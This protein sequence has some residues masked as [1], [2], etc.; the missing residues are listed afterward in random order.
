[1]NDPKWVQ[2]KTEDGLNLP[3][4]LFHAPKSKEVVI[5]LHGMGSSVFYDDSGKLQTVAKKLVQKNISFFPFNNRGANLVRRFTVKKDGKEIKKRYGMAYEI[6]K[7]CCI[8]INA[9]LKY[10]KLLGF[11]EFILMGQSTGANKI[12]VYN[13]YQ[14]KNSIK[15]YILTAGGDDTGIFYQMFEDSNFRQFLKIANLKIKRGEGEEL[16]KEIF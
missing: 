4:L 1:M 13:H 9:A 10:L 12:C 16:M 2:F 14:P 3:G 5:Y 11:E 8:D 7:E 15:K 6:I